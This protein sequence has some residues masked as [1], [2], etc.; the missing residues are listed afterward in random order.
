MSALDPSQIL[1]QLVKEPGA[2]S[3]KMGGY[4]APMFEGSN[5]IEVG[6]RSHM[7]RGGYVTENAPE[8]PHGGL[9]SMQRGKIEFEGSTDVQVGGYDHII[10]PR[11]ERDVM[12][13]PEALK[14]HMEPWLRDKMLPEIPRDKVMYEGSCEVDVGGRDHFGAGGQGRGWVPDNYHAPGEETPEYN[15]PDSRIKNQRPHTPSA[16]FARGEKVTPFHVRRQIR[17]SDGAPIGRESWDT[18]K[19]LPGLTTTHASFKPV[20]KGDLVKG[21]F[22]EGF[23]R[24]RQSDIRQDEGRI[25]QEKVSDVKREN[26]NAARKRFIDTNQN[27]NT[28]NPITGEYWGKPHNHA[29][30]EMVTCNESAVY[31]DRYM[32]H[33][34]RPL[35]GPAQNGECSDC[36]PINQNRTQLLKREGMSAKKA[37]LRGNVRQLFQH[38]D[39]YVVPKVPTRPANL[40]PLN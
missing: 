22:G 13:A 15:N 21:R 37:S 35:P 38:H 34:K 36:K 10:D 4:E 26:N 19:H 27:R 18:I 3:G 14:G 29:F 9:K 24:R 7:Q 11:F 8:A 28:Y 25:T 2:Q 23:Q 6:G 20:G 40:H 1:D 12:R 16:R 17:G 33:T 32:H 31:Q 39:G 30:Q 5:K